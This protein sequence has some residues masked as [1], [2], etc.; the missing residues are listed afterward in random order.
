MNS[1][2]L[3]ELGEKT[4]KILYEFEGQLLIRDSTIFDDLSKIMVTKTI[5]VDS[6]GVAFSQAHIEEVE[7]KEREI[8][9]NTVS[10]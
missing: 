7:R 2:I 8:Y 10:A 1:N 6:L 3:F 9:R 5:S 4:R